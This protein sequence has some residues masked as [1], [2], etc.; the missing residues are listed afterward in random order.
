MNQ[1]S[2]QFQAR[3][4]PPEVDKVLAMAL[5]DVN[6]D[7]MLD[8]VVLQTDGTMQRLS[9]TVEDQTWRMEAIAQWAN[10]PGD[11]AVATPRLLLADMDNNGGLD[12]IASLP[13]DGRL[14][15]SEVQGGLRLLD[16]PLPGRIFAVA[17]LTGDGKLDLLGLSETGQPLRLVNQSTKNYAWLTL[18]P[19]ATPAPG[20]GRINAFALGGEVDVRAGLL[21]QKQPITVPLLHFG[22]GEQRTANIARIVWPNGD[23]QAEFKLQANQMVVA[24]QRLKGSCPWVFAYDGAGMSFITD[25][26]WRSPLGLRINSQ[27]TADVVMTE[28][29]IKIRGDQLL[30]RDGMYDVRITAELWETHFF[31]H[32]SLLVVD[33][34]ADASPSLRPPL[35]CMLQLCRD[36]LPTPG[37]TRA[38]RSLRVYC[39]VMGATSTP[40]GAVPIR[41]LRAIIMLKSTSAQMCRHRGHYG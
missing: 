15:L 4:L 12:L 35:L 31:D 26:L 5:A 14:W 8:L 13:A 36:Q 20:D 23:V 38:R 17:D 22:L 24:R 2:G 37:M 34:P 39:S 32:V 40:L 1:R 41:V 25:F 29:W 19:R 28:D 7:S 21:Y 30:P 9:Y 11:V 18:R 3:A 6:S 33:H 27:D 10:F 16:R